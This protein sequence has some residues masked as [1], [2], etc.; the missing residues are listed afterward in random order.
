MSSSRTVVVLGALLGYHALSAADELRDEALDDEH[1]AHRQDD[2]R[3]GVERAG[4]DQHSLLQAAGR[5]ATEVRAFSHG[6]TVATN[7]LLEGRGARTVLV[8]EAF[9]RRYLNGA[10]PVGYRVRYASDKP[11]EP[12]PWF[13]IVGVVAVILALISAAQRGPDVHGDQDLAAAAPPAVQR[14]TRAQTAVTTPT[15]SRVGPRAVSA[16]G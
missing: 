8:N 5:D 3:E 15:R 6:M 2:Q 13:E 12:E 11:E 10:S 14:L 7:A 9:A 1:R 4:R 16:S